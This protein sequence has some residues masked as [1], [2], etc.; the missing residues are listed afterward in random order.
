MNLTFTF[1]NHEP[2]E[3]DAHDILIGGI[4]ALHGLA[5]WEGDIWLGS[6]FDRFLPHGL[7]AGTGIE[8][9]SGI[10]GGTGEDEVVLR[11]G[12]DNPVIR[13][14]QLPREIL[15]QMKQYVRGE[16]HA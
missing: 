10:G 6:V 5:G 8:I 16:E 13:S 3:F 11:L 15:E 2:V 7:P 4:V 12:W 14:H 9:N 1:D